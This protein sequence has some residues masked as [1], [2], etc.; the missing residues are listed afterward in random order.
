[1]SRLRI[2]AVY[3]RTAQRCINIGFAADLYRATAAES[4]LIHL[5]AQQQ[6]A[7]ILPDLAEAQARQRRRV[8]ADVSTLTGLS[9][10][11]FEIVEELD[12]DAIVVDDQI[13]WH[14]H[15]L[16]V[17]TPFSEQRLLARGPGSIMVPFGDGRSALALPLAAALKMPV[18]FYHTTW[19]NPLVQSQTPADHMCADAVGISSQLSAAA[20]AAGVPYTFEIET[21]DDVVEGLLQ[22]AM[23]SSSRLIAMARS[24]R[25]TVGSYVD[26]ALRRSPVPLLVV[27][28]PGGK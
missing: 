19:R 22:C 14:C 5:P 1:M 25:T 18:I 10:D 7:G 8:V 26:H 6:P 11:Q 28:S 27:A 20:D 16:T 13:A 12:P 15:H 2:A 4:L 17:L 3:R 24:T 23:R 9:P 21:A